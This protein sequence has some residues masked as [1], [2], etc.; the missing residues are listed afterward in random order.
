MN[1]VFWDPLDSPTDTIKY[2]KH[3]QHASK[4]EIFDRYFYLD[5]SGD[6]IVIRAKRNI[7]ETDII[8][9]FVEPF[10]LPDLNPGHGFDTYEKYKNKAKSDKHKDKN[11]LYSDS[12]YDCYDLILKLLKNYGGNSSYLNRYFIKGRTLPELPDKEELE[13]SELSFENPLLSKTKK[14]A[15][16]FH[17]LLLDAIGKMAPWYA[18]TFHI[19][20]D[21]PEFTLKKNRLRLGESRAAYARPTLNREKSNSYLSLFC[22]DQNMYL[23]F[24]TN[25]RMKRGDI[26]QWYCKSPKYGRSFNF[27]KWFTR[28]NTWNLGSK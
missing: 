17:P 22:V 11:I 12:D 2:Y 20:K 13:D 16:F 5:T 19:D 28:V 1:V 18:E 4:R 24:R 23:Q 27:D 21:D 14:Y 26:V 8:I 25:E 15:L 7:N 3:Y 10:L 9:G 6:E